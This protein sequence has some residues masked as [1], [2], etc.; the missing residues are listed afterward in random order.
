MNM[1]KLIVDMNAKN[2]A[3]YLQEKCPEDC[4]IIVNLDTAGSSV[5]GYL[6]G[7]PLYFANSEQFG[8]YVI[9][10]KNRTLDFSWERT[11]KATDQFKDPYI[12]TVGLENPPDSVY[13]L[14]RFDNAIW[15]S[16]DYVI[17]KMKQSGEFQ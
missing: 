2:V 1:S 10:D 6:G 8:T 3:M 17:Y 4:E 13:E 9:W 15:P 7:V 14:K 11:L 16:E 12:L 5:S